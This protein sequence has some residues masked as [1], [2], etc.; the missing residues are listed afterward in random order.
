M[1]RAAAVIGDARVNF[2]LRGDKLRVPSLGVGVLNRPRVTGL[3]ERPPL[4][5]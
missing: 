4:A 5:R 3:I 1:A 2:G